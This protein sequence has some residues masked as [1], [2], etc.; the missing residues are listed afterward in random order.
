MGPARQPR[1]PLAFPSG[2]EPRFPCLEQFPTVFHWHC[3]SV[4][5]SHPGDLF[6]LSLSICDSPSILSFS[7]MALRF[8]KSR[9]QLF[10]R[11][12]LDLGSSEF[13][14]W[15]EWR[16]RFG[17][18]T[19]Q[20]WYSLLVASYQMCMLS[21]YLINGGMNLITWL[22]VIC[23]TYLVPGYCFSLS[24]AYSLEASH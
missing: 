11:M 12:S 4:P 8:L 18:R 7:F 19:T 24:T 1:S 21:V 15:L 13:F 16:Y 17:G 6:V 2:G 20:R 5:G 22:G 3:F 10:F 9:N 23:Q 14:W